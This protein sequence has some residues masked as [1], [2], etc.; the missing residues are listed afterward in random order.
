VYS[1]N[2]IWEPIGQQCDTFKNN[3]IHVV[4]DNIIIAKLRE[5]QEITLRLICEKGIG[6]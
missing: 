6:K 3:P 1:Q 5:N 2:L 4:Y